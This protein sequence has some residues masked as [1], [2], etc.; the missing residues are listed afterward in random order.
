MFSTSLS[1]RTIYLLLTCVVW[2]GVLLVGAPTA[3]AA[4]ECDDPL[5]EFSIES[6]AS[7]V[8][9]KFAQFSGVWKG[10]W[11]GRLCSS[12]VITSVDKDGGVEGI[13]SWGR[14]RNF[15]A[16]YRAFESE[17]KKGKIKMG[18]R[19]RFTFRMGEKPGEI[20][21]ER[22]AGGQ[23]SR[24]TME[25]V[26]TPS[27]KKV[28]A[29]PATSAAGANAFIGSWCG[30]WKPGPENR[31][32]VERVDEEG[33]ARG[34]Y[35]WIKGSRKFKGKIEGDKLRFSF[36][37]FGFA[38]VAYE[39]QADGTLKGTWKTSGGKSTIRSERC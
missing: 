7:D 24:V 29:L 28:A 32:T 21:G 14:G 38:K 2:A 1:P 35:S 30:Q 13:Y 37:D 26:D 5:P 6:P 10:K 16:G 18:R 39:L 8:P 12:F 22:R 27:A 25:K 36:P 17:I 11:G 34:V 31:L 9:E 15:D 3:Q 23:T 19:A 4:T 20:R 33:K